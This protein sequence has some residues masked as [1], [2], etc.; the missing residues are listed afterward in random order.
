MRTRT[1]GVVLV[2]GGFHVVPT[3]MLV[4]SAGFTDLQNWASLQ[5][6]RAL[7]G[8]MD[9]AAGMAD[10]D[11]AGHS[12]AAKYEPAAQAVVTAVGR[13]VAQLG[14]TANGLYSMAMNYIETDADV[15]AN[16]MRPYEL[17]ASSSPGCDEEPLNVQIPSAVGHNNSV[18]DEIV[19]QFW[20]EGDPGKLRQ[21]G[22]DWKK[23]AELVSTLGLEGDKRVQTVTASSTST[24]VDG[25]AA[26]W[27]KM[28]DG[29]AT[30]GPLLNSI[31]NAAFK[32]G[33]ACEAYAQAS[34]TCA[35]RWRTP[36]PSPA[37]SPASGSA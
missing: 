3:D 35:R 18:V 11:D 14:G 36:A 21:A 20:P 30:Q 9:D 16:L 31:T 2:A 25:F 32:L 7:I 29:C 15:A 27:A 5:V 13:A 6:H 37:S 19:A 17:P 1:L 22:S 33:T 26:S 23:L 34:T 12:F 4:A 24:A 8:S 28:H 10:D